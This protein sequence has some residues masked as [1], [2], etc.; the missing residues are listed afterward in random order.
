MMSCVMLE[1]CVVVQERANDKLLPG[2][3][4]MVQTNKDCI[5]L[6]CVYFVLPSCTFIRRAK[7]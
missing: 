3:C 5:A 2:S 1:Q 7:Y 4:C 6:D